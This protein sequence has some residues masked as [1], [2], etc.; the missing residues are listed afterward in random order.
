MPDDL[1]IDLAS[2]LGAEAEQA[3]QVLALYIPDKDRAGIEYG[4]QRRWVLDAAELLAQMGG[5]VTI[6]PPVEGGWYDDDNGR[7]VWERPVILYTYVKPDV[8]ADK[9]LAL[10]EFV[11]RL[12]RETAQGEVVVEFDRQLFRIR[13]FRP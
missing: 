6:L 3:T 7:I 2:A 9:L 10:C 11:H 12:G 5:G 4:S 8:F 1:P 13:E